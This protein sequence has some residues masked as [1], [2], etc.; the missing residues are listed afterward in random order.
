MRTFPERVL[1]GDS[2]RSCENSSCCCYAGSNCE[3]S[4]SKGCIGH[5]FI[6]EDGSK[7]EQDEVSYLPFKVSKIV[8]SSSLMFVCLF[9]FGEYFF[10]TSS[11]PLLAA[12]SLLPLLRASSCCRFFAA[13]VWCCVREPFFYRL[14][15]GEFVCILG[16]AEGACERSILFYNTCNLLAHAQY[17]RVYQAVFSP[18]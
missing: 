1:L 15:L 3:S 6:E 18:P 10:A 16:R 5:V 11:V 9:F 7:V 17:I 8:R 13:K 2:C 12:G 4:I 14:L